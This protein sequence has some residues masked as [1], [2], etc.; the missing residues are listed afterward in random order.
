MPFSVGNQLRGFDTFGHPI[1]VNFK[2]DESYNT[3]MGGVLTIVVLGFTLTQIVI[4]L[5][6]IVTMN[7]PDIT[8]FSKPL[9]AGDREEILPVEFGSYNFVF[10][11]QQT[12]FNF[13][14]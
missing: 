5:L 6:K 2:G 13:G 8:E 3:R 11:F 9:S 10:G 4:S 14:T 1:H 12:F 7:D